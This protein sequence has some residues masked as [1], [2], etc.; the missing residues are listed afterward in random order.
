MNVFS[1][2]CK[3]VCAFLH[4]ISQANN[5]DSNLCNHEEIDGSKRHLNN[6]SFG[7]PEITDGGDGLRLHS[8]ANKDILKLHHEWEILEGLRDGQTIH[9]K[10]ERYQGFLLKRRKWP[11]KGWHKVI[12]NQCCVCT[13]VK[14]PVFHVGVSLCEHIDLVVSLE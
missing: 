8:S 5:D 3:C 10:P 7:I 9:Q 13:H 2:I 4:V 14:Y 1:F 12:A 6:F 11:L